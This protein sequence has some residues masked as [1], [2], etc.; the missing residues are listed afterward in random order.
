M[1]LASA[2]RAALDRPEHRPAHGPIDREPLRK[3]LETAR[4][5]AAAGKRAEADETFDA[6]LALAE[7][8]PGA[9][10]LIED[11]RRK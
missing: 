10:K 11:A 7:H 3:A 9:R 5:L 4:A 1:D 2:G 8:D 6:L